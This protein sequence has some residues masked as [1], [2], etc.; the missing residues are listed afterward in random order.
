MLVMGL[1]VQVVPKRSAG[2]ATSGPYNGRAAG[3]MEAI[4]SEET[5]LSSRATAPAIGMRMS[6]RRAR[7]ELMRVVVW[8]GRV[9]WCG[10]G[11]CVLFV[12]VWHPSNIES[13]TRTCTDL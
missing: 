1:A 3:I 2:P 10:V 11:V 9:W 5:H 8:C 4:I 7:D 13:H 12:A 6:V